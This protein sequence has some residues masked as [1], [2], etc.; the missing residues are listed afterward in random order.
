MTGDVDVLERFGAVTLDEMVSEAA[1]LSRVDR[2][3][4]VPR[5]AL[6]E[7]LRTMDERTRVLEI[8][9][10]RGFSYESVYFDTPDLLSF[11][12]AA[13]PRRR[14]FKLRTRAYLDT[15]T[16]FLEIKT[17]G[18]RGMTVKERSEYDL[19]SRSVL[20]DNARDEVA[21][22]F[23]AI[24][25]DVRRAADLQA[26]LVTRYSRTTLLAPDATARAT[27]DTD[28]RWDRPG[29]DGFAL[30]EVA[31]VETKSPSCPSDVDRL[32]WRAGHRPVS[33]SKYA[34]GLAALRPDLPRNRW[35]RLLRGA[36]AGADRS[37]LHTRTRELPCAAA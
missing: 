10:A 25:V 18:T 36:F 19:D 2:K 5:G 35:D 13:Q 37:T 6:V 33:V 23:E 16:A 30:P 34:T 26:T 7:I 24:G 22:A 9:G 8:D 20:T 27:V 17:R 12:M 15:D 28:L 14:R 32:L 21:T 3:Y 31:I 1:L 11:R 29:D 4:V